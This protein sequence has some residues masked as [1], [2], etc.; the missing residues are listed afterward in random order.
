MIFL[1][2]QDNCPLLFNPT[3]DLLACMAPANFTGCRLEMGSRLD[4]YWANTKRGEVAVQRCPH[5][6]GKSEV[7]C[8]IRTRRG[9]RG[10]GASCNEP[11]SNQGHRPPPPL[12]DPPQPSPSSPSP[13]LLPLP[14]LP[15][16][17]FCQED[18]SQ[19]RDMEFSRGCYHVQLF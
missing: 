2:L 12:L 15:P 5:A 17:R 16:F 1:S 10:G 13:P 19:H 11:F 14:L 8:S 9:G 7:Q 18:V 6:N 3:Q 4:I